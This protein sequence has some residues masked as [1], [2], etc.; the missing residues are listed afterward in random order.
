MKRSVGLM[1]QVKRKSW[2][3]SRP[4]SIEHL[5]LPMRLTKTTI[6]LWWLIPIWRPMEFRFQLSMWNNGRL[7]TKRKK[8][9]IRNKGR[10]NTTN[11]RKNDLWKRLWKESWGIDIRVRGNPKAMN[12][13]RSILFTQEPFRLHL[14]L[15]LDIL[16]LHPIADTLSWLSFLGTIDGILSSMMRMSGI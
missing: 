3:T 16:L 8:V 5:G 14:T 13:V 11:Q 6:G 9:T 12:A 10:T 1:A 15:S 4:I 7:E 2:E